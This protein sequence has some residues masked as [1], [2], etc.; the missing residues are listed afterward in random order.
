MVESPTHPLAGVRCIVLR[1][2]SRVNWH[3]VS[4]QRAA[5]KPATLLIDEYGTRCDVPGD[6]VGGRDDCGND[7]DNKGYRGWGREKAAAAWLVS[8]GGGHCFGGADGGAVLAESRRPRAYRL[9]GDL[10]PEHGRAVYR[11]RALPYWPLAAVGAQGLAGARS[12]Q[13]LRA[14]R[15][16]LHAAL[17]QRARRVGAPNAADGHLAL[18]R[19]RCGAGNPDTTD[20]ALALDV[21]LRRYGLGGRLRASR[22][23]A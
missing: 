19:L 20:A 17:L 8:R 5:L 12:C 21:A 22:V 18:R 3:C 9:A 2:N 13:H 11:E 14:D 6:S 23:R 1:A 15:G 16:H 4:Q 10:R 7:N